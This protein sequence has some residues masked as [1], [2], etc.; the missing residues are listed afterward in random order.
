MVW[1]RASGLGWPS[2]VYVGAARLG[3]CA[4]ISVN[5]S[6]SNRVCVRMRVRVRMRVTMT[7]IMIGVIVRVRVRINF[8]TTASPNT[9]K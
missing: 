9:H 5:L 2:G 6:R 8:H 4:K 7:V 3:P 1:E